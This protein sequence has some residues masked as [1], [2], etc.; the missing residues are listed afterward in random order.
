M[1]D[2]LT[3]Q[4]LINPARRR[5]FNVAYQLMHKVS[6]MANREVLDASQRELRHPQH[7]MSS[8]SRLAVSV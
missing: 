7:F 3:P 6:L 1:G 2:T 8:T 4:C 5:L